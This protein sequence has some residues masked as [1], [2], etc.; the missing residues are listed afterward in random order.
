MKT[1]TGLLAMAALAYA[2][3][4]GR[5]DAVRK[6]ETL[7]VSV[8]FQDHKIGDALDYLREVTGLNL[9]LMPRAAEK[10]GD[11]KVRLKARDLSVRSILKL[12][13]ANHGLTATWR[14]GAV[15]IL[16]QEDLQ[17]SVVIEMYD[18][19][20]QLFKLQDFPGP[21]MELVS[22]KSGNGIQSGITILEAEKE[23]PVTPEFLV[24]IVKENTGG[25]SWDANKN[26][27][28]Q[29]T[30]GMLVVTQSTTVHREIK[31]LLGKLSQYR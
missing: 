31:E 3:D 21:K 9:V 26:A 4:T 28:I 15:L 19:R 8:D 23:P 18:V 6:L 30:N 5:E 16:P 20:A 29:L 11:F 7:K 17:D 24:Q 13:L 14:D 2:G 25:Q 10:A 12:V 22:P 27:S 1:I